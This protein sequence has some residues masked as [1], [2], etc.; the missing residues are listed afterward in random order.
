MTPGT[1]GDAADGCREAIAGASLHAGI[2]YN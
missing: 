1:A 2:G